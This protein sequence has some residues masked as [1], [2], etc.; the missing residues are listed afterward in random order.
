MKILIVGAGVVGVTSAYV[1]ATRGHDVTV[2]ERADKPAAECSFANGGQLSYSHAESW[3]SPQTLA[4]VPRWLF[5]KDSPLKINPKL[6]ADMLRWLLKFLGNCRTTKSHQHTVSLL[7]LGLYSRK[8]MADILTMTG[9]DCDHRRDGILHYFLHQATFYKAKKQLEFQKK[10]GCKEKLLDAEEAIALEPA[11]DQCRHKL[12]GAIHAPLD[13]TGNVHRFTTKLAR[14]CEQE[15][16]VN[17]HYLTSLESLSLNADTVQ[18]I[19]TN[20]GE[21]LADH[22]VIAMGASTAIPLRNI[23]IDIPIYPLKGYSLTFENSANAPQMSLTDHAGKMVYTPVDNTLRIAG[24]AELVGH[25][26]A[27]RP[28]RI[29]GLK[30]VIGQSFPALMEQNAQ[31]SQWACLRPTTPDGPPIIGNT[32]VRNLTINAGH[33]TLG[34]TQAAGSAFLL[35]DCIDNKET[36]I[37]MDGLAIERFL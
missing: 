4:M 12:K 21:M 30:R 8:V 19:V 33:G 16:G 24:T 31:L 6:D 37:S 17:F 20:K 5:Q 14:L 9:I 13:E 26:T 15:Y 2:I 22:Y 35:A 34:W 3:A 36:E 10:L 1:L 11:L 18:H 28:E 27:I 25:N 32:P 29:E 7:K 23:G